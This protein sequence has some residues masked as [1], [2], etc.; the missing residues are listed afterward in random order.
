MTEQAAPKRNL[1]PFWILLSIS[2]LPYI[3]SWIWYANMDNMPDI[4]PNNRGELVEPVRPLENMIIETVDGEKLETN[5]FKGKWTLLTA[6]SSGCDKSCMQ[7][8]Y[9]MRQ[10][11]RLMGEERLKIKRL[12]VLM[13]EQQLDAFSEKIKQFGEMDLVAADA[14]DAAKL[15]EKMT[16]NGNS[17]ENR[18]FIVDPLANLMMAYPQD[19]NP[20]DIARDF[21]RLLKVVRI[22]D[23]KEAG[24]TL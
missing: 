24:Q 23:P 2:A 14:K 18:I 19:D 11:R 9:Y 10:V 15:L 7:N 16:V 17:P 1:K 6:G 3:L 22:G 5:T 13:D 12:F 8:I 21:R 4:A 20:E